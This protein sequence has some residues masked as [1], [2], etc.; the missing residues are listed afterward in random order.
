MPITLSEGGRLEVSFVAR[1]SVNYRV[2]LTTERLLPIQEQNCLLG[3]E[4]TVPQRCVAHPVELFLS[5][6]ATTDGE[7]VTTG[8]SSPVDTG[9]WGPEMG[10]NLG[11]IAAVG[12]KRYTLVVDVGR[13][14][15]TLQKTNPRLVVEVASED[16]RWTYV[17]IGLL[18]ILGGFSALL[19]LILMLTGGEGRDLYLRRSETNRRNS[20]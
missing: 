4:A 12:G 8:N 5:W 20:P 13:S 19:A 9:Y 14:S 18:F 3:I 16:L 17:W 6:S 15:V 2:H 7:L 10:K 1:W 11:R